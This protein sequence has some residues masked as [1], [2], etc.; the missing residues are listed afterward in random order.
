MS[1]PMERF[2]LGKVNFRLVDFQASFQLVG[3][4][5]RKINHLKVAR[6]RTTSV[7]QQR[8]NRSQ[9]GASLSERAPVLID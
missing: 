1:T 9:F 5:V 6:D 8:E 4:L 3:I 7:A 2:I